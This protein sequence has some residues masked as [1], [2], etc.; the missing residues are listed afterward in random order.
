[1][2]GRLPRLAVLDRG[3]FFDVL[4]SQNEGEEDPAE[5]VQSEVRMKRKKN[6][7]QGLVDL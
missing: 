3:N 2:S 4:A 7:S 5:A 6:F 1:M